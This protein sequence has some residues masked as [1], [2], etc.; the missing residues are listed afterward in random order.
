MS[1]EKKKN[2]VYT[3]EEDTWLRY[4]H[5]VDTDRAIVENLLFN[6]PADGSLSLHTKSRLCEYYGLLYSMDEVIHK[7]ADENHYDETTSSYIVSESLAFQF[8]L[9]LQA[10]VMAKEVLMDNNCPI[11]VH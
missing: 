8:N 10:L 4:M 3:L 5:K 7:M 11:S 2:I 9:F 6:A 1:S